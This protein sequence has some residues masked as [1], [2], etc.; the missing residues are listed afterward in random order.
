MNDHDTVNFTCMHN[1]TWRRACAV[2]DALRKAPDYERVV[3]RIF[4]RRAT[5]AEFVTVLQA[6]ADLPER[7]SLCED[8]LSVDL[9]RLGVSAALLVDCVQSA[10]APEV[11]CSPIK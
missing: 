9:P 7:L 11:C 3:S 6:L 1:T 5:P 4:H 8:S 2:Q 10:C